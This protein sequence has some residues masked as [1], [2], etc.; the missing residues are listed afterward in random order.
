[1]ML[2]L[3]VTSG[4]KEQSAQQSVGVRIGSSKLKTFPIY[5]NICIILSF[6]CGVISDTINNY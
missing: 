6:N 3:G 5:S 2:T 4:K 1:M